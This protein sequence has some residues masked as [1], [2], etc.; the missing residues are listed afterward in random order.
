MIKKLLILIFFLFTFGYSTPF[1]LGMFF[2]SHYSGILTR[3]FVNEKSALKLVGIYTSY[4]E[5][6]SLKHRIKSN[7]S[8]GGEIEFYFFSNCSVMPYF[9]I[10]Y[11]I[12]GNSDMGTDRYGFNIMFCTDV[13]PFKKGKSAGFGIGVGIAFRKFILYDKWLNSKYEEKATVL[14]H[15]SIEFFYTL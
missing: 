9:S 7:Y 1:S 5:K 13:Y 14:P 4:T 15:F 3:F 6:D 2:S 11:G 12:S 8:L 10:G